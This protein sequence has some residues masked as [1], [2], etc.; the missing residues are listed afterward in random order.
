MSLSYNP[1]GSISLLPTPFTLITSLTLNHCDL[2]SLQ[3]LEQFPHLEEF[4][5]KFNNITSA[6]ELDR[7][8][9]GDSLRSLNFVGNDIEYLESCRY[10][11]LV[12]RFQKLVELNNVDH[13]FKEVLKIQKKGKVET[14]KIMEKLEKLDQMTKR[15]NTTSPGEEETHKKENAHPDNLENISISRV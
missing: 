1:I 15:H 14:H 5:F 4:S 11:K 9:C 3:G 6:K 12:K 10:E 7:L 2:S 8:R 13:R